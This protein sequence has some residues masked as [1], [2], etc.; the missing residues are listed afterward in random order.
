M[1][2]L[3]WVATVLLLAGALNGLSGSA[4]ASSTQHYRGFATCN[5]TYRP[6]P[7]RN[8]YFGSG[9]GA[10]FIAKTRARVRYTLCVTD[11]SS[12]AKDCFTR[13]T[14]RTRVP[15]TIYLFNKSIV[16][17]VGSYRLKWRVRG[18]GVVARATLSMLLGD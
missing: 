2:H 5:A 13:R 11:K 14:R 16:S 1:R 17:D 15:S 4:G 12:K 8:C 18:H 6:D 10:T 3:R 7:D 9:F